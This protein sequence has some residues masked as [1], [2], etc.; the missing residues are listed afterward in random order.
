MEI[1]LEAGFYKLFDVLDVRMDTMPDNG[2]EAWPFQTLIN[3]L[4]KIL[5]KNVLFT[6]RPTIAYQL[7]QRRFSDLERI[8]KLVPQ[9]PKQVEVWNEHDNPDSFTSKC[10]SYTPW[11]VPDSAVQSFVGGVLYANRYQTA[12]TK[13]ISKFHDLRNKFGEFSFFS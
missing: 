6:F 3:K 9:R 2:D 10:V 13:H 7:V 4:E 12:K 1:V 8:I 11:Y 5:N